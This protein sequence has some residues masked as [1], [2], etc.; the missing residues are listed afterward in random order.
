VRLPIMIS[1]RLEAARMWVGRKVERCVISAVA[2]NPI[3]T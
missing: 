2:T 1:W 3:S